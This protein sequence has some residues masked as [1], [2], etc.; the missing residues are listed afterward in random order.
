MGGVERGA[1]GG[2]VGLAVVVLPGRFDCVCVCVC[3]FG[4]FLIWPWARRS[5]QAEEVVSSEFLP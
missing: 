4:F 1:F 5:R 3:L 2:W